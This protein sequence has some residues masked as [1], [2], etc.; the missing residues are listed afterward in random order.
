MCFKYIAS[1]SQGFNIQFVNLIQSCRFAMVRMYEA[2]IFVA[3]IRKKFR[4]CFEFLQKF[5]LA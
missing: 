3:K 1:I 5:F 2:V 4:N